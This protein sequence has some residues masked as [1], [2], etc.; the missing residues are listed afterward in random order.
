[1]PGAAVLSAH[2]GRPAEHEPIAAVVGADALGND[3]FRMLVDSVRDYAIFLLNPQGII[4]SWNV[5]AQR[6]KGYGAHEIIGQHF[7]RFYTADA[8]AMD[9]PAEELR[10][11]RRDGRFEDEG[12]RIRKDGTRFW[13]NVII[14]PMV[15]PS[16]DLLG[17]SKITRDLTE[18]RE[19]EER[20]RQSEENLRSLV[21]G[22]KGNAIFPLDT[23]GVISG[24]N[25]GA[26]R[27]TGYSAS[28][29][30]GRHWSVFFTHD[31]C[32]AGKPQAALTEAAQT[33]RAETIGW[34]VCKDGTRFWAEGRLTL[35]RDRDGMARGFVHIVRD[36]SERRRVQELEN[37]GQ[38]ITEFIAMLAHELRN[39]LAPIGN[40]VG[41]LEK[42]GTTP[43]LTWCAQLIG[44]Q[45]G[46]LT[47]LVDDL[48]DA[49]RITS[50]KIQL[51]KEPLV[52]NEVVAAAVE[53]VR[54]VVVAYG[55]T[56]EVSLPGQPIEMTGD[57]TRL[58]QIVVNLLNNAA[59]YT[60]NGGHVA[61]QL[62]RYGSLATI[63][64][65]DN[66]I[67]MSAKLVESAFDLFVQGERTLDR[68]EGGLG[69]GL[70]LVRRIA[71]LHGGTVTA[72]SAGP[73]RGSEFTVLLPVGPPALAA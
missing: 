63:R 51:R 4:I 58:T 19:H 45:L 55:H 67:G 44:R 73:G 62:E 9:W 27:L 10:R 11:A 29:V 37:E 24:W 54:P 56:L 2:P 53:S 36:L 15:A 50:G 31:D 33:G 7:S 49:S 34:R 23:E 30:L 52:L 46:H 3:M 39:P 14:T 69:I 17:Y 12:W 60:P 22:V 64:V 5:G 57:P 40:A 13:A 18:R 38:R 8:L 68:A 66:G 48:L 26:E 59:K 32:E 71:V 16:G 35:L 65:V 25:A 42:L 72:H 21:E 41:I 1:V 20:L 28:D 6:I 47:R 70:P 61:L 43:Q